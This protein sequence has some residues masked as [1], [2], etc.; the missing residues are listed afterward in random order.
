MINLHIITHI[1]QSL[2]LFFADIP[3]P[4]VLIFFVIFI[5]YIVNNI[6]SIYISNITHIGILVHIINRNY[7]FSPPC[8]KFINS[9][10]LF[11][12]WNY[13]HLH[14]YI[15]KYCNINKTFDPNI[16][17]SFDYIDPLLLSFHILILFH[18]FLYQSCKWMHL[19]ILTI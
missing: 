14:V 7:I 4:F 13:N 10:L 19:L 18:P 2:F 16:F 15:Y 11:K 3:F 12:M 1:N 8:L 17:P 6:N 9:P 5:Y